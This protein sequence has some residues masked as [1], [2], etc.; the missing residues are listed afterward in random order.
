MEVSNTTGLI[1]A[2]YWVCDPCL[3]KAWNQQGRSAPRASAPAP[4]SRQLCV[5]CSFPG[6]ALK[7]T[8]EGEW[9]HVSCMLLSNRLT[10]LNYTH[11]EPIIAAAAPADP[12]LLS[13]ASLPHSLF[14][15]VPLPR[16]SSLDLLHLRL[17]GRADREVLRGGLPALHARTLPAPLPTA[18]A[19]RLPALRP[20]KPVKPSWGNRGNRGNREG[21]KG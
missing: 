8:W 12:E 9:C 4:L 1:N 3:C 14:V 13:F 21:W 10:V 11:M 6:G 15:H 5:C 18:R 17:R 2:H 19:P 7:R 20:V 16:G